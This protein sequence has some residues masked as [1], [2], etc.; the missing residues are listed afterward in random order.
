MAEDTRSKIQRLE[1]E[2]ERWPDNVANALGESFINRDGEDILSGVTRFVLDLKGQVEGA[3]ACANKAGELH[4]EVL[5]KL[6]L[7]EDLGMVF[8][9]LKSSDCPEGRMAFDVKEGSELWKLEQELTKRIALEA[10]LEKLKKPHVPYVQENPSD[11]ITCP[12]CRGKEPETVKDMCDLCNGMGVVY[13]FIAEKYAGK[14]K[15][16]G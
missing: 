15:K 8:G 13:R 2:I 5:D 16:D 7:A 3:L 11:G 1:D 4:G 12:A 14:G 9:I 10:G 6:R